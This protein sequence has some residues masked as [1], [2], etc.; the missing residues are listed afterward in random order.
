[1]KLNTKLFLAVQI[2]LLFLLFGFSPAVTPDLILINGKIITVDQK[3]TIAQAVAIKDGKITAVGTSD[4][5]KKLAGSQTK[6]I[7][8]KGK[9]AVPGLYDAHLHPETASVSELTEKIPDIHTVAELLLWIKSETQIKRPGEWIIM[10]KMF[11]T[12]LR[13]LKGPTLA[14]LDSIAPNHP[15]F[16][17][18]SYGG[19][20]NSCAMK[21]SQINKDTNNPGL[22]KDKT[23]GKL[24][25]IIRAA[26][27]RLINYPRGK[28]LSYQERLDALQAQLA[29]YNEIGIT[30]V[31]SGD[32]DENNFKMYQ[33]LHNT[34]KLTV[35]V[36]QNVVLPRSAAKSYNTL[37]DSLKSLNY[38]TGTG[39][40]WVRYGALKVLLDGGILT[41]TA[42]M[43]E[44]WG[45]KAKTIFGITDPT[46]RG[47][48]NYS[49]EDLLTIARAADELNWKFTAHSTGG[50]GVD[51]LL[52]VYDEVN[53]T[54]PIKDLRWSIIHGNF[55]T[56]EAIEK[57]NRLNVYAD[58]QPAWFYKDA[59]AMKY[60]LGEETIKTFQNYR[61]LLNGGVMV[62]GGSDH[63]V[64]WDPN[65]SI[66]PYNPFLAMYTVV[67]RKTERGTV[68]LPDEAIT[69]E[70]A[71]KM[72]TINNAYAS[73]EEKIKGSI[74]P[75]KLA[76]IA[77]LSEDLYDCPADQIKEIVSDM[78]IVGG[79]VVYE[80]K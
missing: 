46:Y 52:D 50:G 34:G 62:N 54:K 24:T 70:E 42:Y 41:G 9:T 12:R 25:G 80:R 31:C 36:F 65:T 26:A 67:T 63:M 27:F 39:D 56:K 7:D 47:V 74:E 73:F 58:A 37:L 43:R 13:E 33:D 44:P 3:S 16:L 2:N 6:M 28:E 30:S 59:D 19:M 51:L 55:F 18:G 79:K 71:L 77:V 57:M 32:N 68:I 8:L 72:Y 29:R 14:Q 64:G 20:I 21:V 17:N 45:D 49:R 60:I 5:I 1:M 23:T 35:R 69:R 75:G 48:V 38:K 76:D 66:N 78:T 53:K 15:I 4:D 11:F 40:E 22:L 61:S 10:P